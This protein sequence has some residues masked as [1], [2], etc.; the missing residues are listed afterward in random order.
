MSSINTLIKSASQDKKITLK[1]RKVSKNN[2]I[3]CREPSQFFY[4]SKIVLPKS[5]FKN[6]S[7]EV[8]P[9]IY[10]K[11]TMTNK[12]NISS[13]KN[14]IMRKRLVNVLT[15]PS[16]VSLGN[17]VSPAKAKMDFPMKPRDAL[18]LYSHELTG[19]EQ[20]EVL[21]YPEVYYLGQRSSKIQARL[22]FSNFG[23]DD[24]SSNLKISKGD[25]LAFRYEVQG[26]LGK[27]SFGTVCECF[28]HKR[29]EKVAVKIIRNKKRFYHQAGIEVS[30]LSALREK[31]I[32][33]QQPLIKMKSY[34]IF[35]KHVCITFDLWNHNLYE[36][37][38]GNKFQGLSISLIRRFT[39]QILNGLNFLA[40]L[41]LIHCDLK[42]ENVLLKHPTRS[43]VVIIDFGSATF[44]KEKQHTY[45]Q[46]RFYRAPEIIL[47]I[48]YTTAID[49]WSLGCMLCELFTGKPLLP[50]ESEHD[51]LV[52]IIEMF[53]LPSASIL[54][55]STKKSLFFEGNILKNPTIK[56]SILKIPGSK[57][58]YESVP[59]ED[60]NFLDFI[61]KCL[62]LD[63]EF[64]ITPKEAL[65]HP[66]I[67]SNIKHKSSK[68]YLERKILKNKIIAL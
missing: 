56:N 34:F 59:T 37:L 26:I 35:R 2:S 6:T 13:V 23:F 38:K 4:T 10:N 21:D 45:I 65:N 29:S 18:V 15:T 49:M 28:D 33:D 42:P 30:I 11:P 41:E 17:L 62:E 68:T 22:E 61:E 63:P 5:A 57:K 50:G 55:Q 8:K 31:D 16:N 27:G 53:G 48:P 36:L 1:R 7:Y 3:I 40:K 20:A 25:H 52:L 32:E 9:T 66:F 12:H 24:N 19:Y 43:D 67:S 64:R 58:L 44:F 47:G 54:S 46:S 51:Q 14:P 39:I 60:Q